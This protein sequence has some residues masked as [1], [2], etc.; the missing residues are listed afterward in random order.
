MY[1]ITVPGLALLAG[2]MALTASA[3]SAK[4]EANSEKRPN[5][6]FLI[7]D[8]QSAH[9]M[10]CTGNEWLKTPAMDYIA[11]NGVRFTR[12]Y[13]TNP[14]SSPA[15][16]GFITGRF[17]GSFTN[18]NGREARDN[19]SSMGIRNVT[20]EVLATTMPAW[21]KKAGYDLVYGGKTHLP[22]PFNP[23]NQG[24]HVI[25]TGIRTDL[26]KAVADY[27]NGNKNNEKPYFIFVSLINPHDICYM[28]IR[29]C[30][31]ADP[32]RSKPNDAKEPIVYL[33]RALKMPEGVGEEEF[34]ARY[35]PPLPPNYEPQQGEPEAI[36][37]LLKKYPFRGEARR[38]YGD[39]DWRRHRWAY[40]RLTEVVDGEIQMILD[41]L[42]SS[43]TEENTVII[44]STDHGDMDASHRLEHKSLLWEESANVPFIISWKGHIKPGVNDTHLISNGL[45]LLPTVCDYAGIKALS[46]P[47]GRSIRPLV[48][49]KKAPWRT[50]LGVEAEVGRMVVSQDG[51]KYMRYDMAGFDEEQI[52]DL[53]KDPWET[54][55][56]TDDP[57]YAKRLAALRKSYDEEWFPEK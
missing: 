50:T 56:F 3:A 28:A 57:A 47:R 35:C 15:R 19:G 22:G 37:A 54:R 8:Q 49:G 27:I 6:I 41:A 34:F 53:K 40:H 26:G 12:A 33:D 48:E 1:H 11:S 39:E 13:T 24:F 30:W 4:K 7:T 29:D 55:H 32:G 2:S 14:V 18:N 10:S 38:K 43:G 36:Q 46:D 23:K 5:I 51:C 16:V 17:P 44:F 9:M 25:S 52:L 21:L 20:P 42:R 31:Y 45:D